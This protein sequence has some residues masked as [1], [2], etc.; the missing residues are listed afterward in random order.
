MEDEK[1][2]VRPFADILRDLGRGEVAD[3]A[4]VMLSDL[5]QTVRATGKKR[6]LHAPRRGGPVQGQHRAAHG[7][8]QARIAP[9]QG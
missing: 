2:Q 4:A 6:P 5:V 7:V 9:A 8:G 1:G 3:E